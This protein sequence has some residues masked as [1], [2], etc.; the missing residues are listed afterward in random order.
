MALTAK[1]VYAI[2]KRQISDME[3]K[4]NSPVR[5]RGTVATAD[6]LPL[7]PDIG[8]MYNIESK[9]IYG[10]AGMNVAWNG[11][12]WDTMGA[13]I[14][15]SLYIK[16]SE[17]SDWVKQQNKPTYTAEEVGALPDTT[18]IPSKTSEL[19]NDS[20]FLT[21]IPDNYLSGTDKTL[22]V[23]GKAADA[24]ATG[25]KITELSADI[26]KKLNKNQGSENSGKIAGI[27]ES[28][29]IVPMFPVSV[30]YNEETNCLE[31]GSDQKMELNKGINLDSTLT[32]TGSAA[33]AGAV[34]EITNSLKEDLD[35]ILSPNLYN[36]ADA[37]ENTAINQDD[38]TEMPF[39]GWLATGY[40]PVSKN[41]VL[42]FSSNE[43]PIPYSTGAFYDKNKQRVDSFGNPNN[44]NNI[45]VTSDGYARFSFGTAPMNLQI[46]KG[47]R[48]TYVPYGELK[49]KVE[50]DNVKEDIAHTKAEVTGIKA[51]V[52]K[53]QEDHTN[54]FN[55]DTVIKGAV[56]SE[57]GY[58]ETS[59]SSWDS[60][61]YIPIKPGMILYFSSNELPIGVASTGAYFDADKKYLSGINNEPTVLTV[62]NGAYYLRF[63][64][65]GGLGD[66]LNTLK[67]EQH[68]ITKFTPYGELYV[69]VNES[70]LPNSILPKWKGLKIL[71]LGDSITAMGGVNGW[72]HWIKQ[73]LLADKVVNVSVA[74]STWQDK[75]ASQTYDGNPQPSTDGNV[76]GNQVQKV[77]NAKANGD[78]DY[79]DFDVITFSFGTN[80]SIDFSVQTKGSVENQFIT[81]YAQNN[82]TVVPLESVNRQT[83]AGAMRY[84]FQKL[85]E[86]YP[87][88]VIFM[89]TP[90]QE[91]YETFDSIYQK[92][93]FIN[94]VADRLGAETI[95]TRRCGIRNIYES[96]T[97]IDYDHPEQSG[98][99]P[100][101]TDL[102]DGIHTNENGAKKIAK[103]NAREIIKYFMIN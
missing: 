83:L 4:L 45:T 100:I 98:V 69:T 28:G 95:D 27:N 38:G 103:Y 39:D 20:G 1:K 99:A 23:S 57:N 80:D 54:L 6:L 72:T 65:N 70:A 74:G 48:T 79:Q 43:E 71:T 58:L 86:A 9:S 13:P 67:I 11:V 68:G 61:D 89:C 47:S 17:L 64:K 30:D 55:K 50:V 5:Y 53:I 35:N 59:F 36:P 24:K 102:L 32:K 101:Q 96:Q 8:D 56:L 93:D 81:N 51:E 31:F 46:E 37:K 19:Q 92:G 78:A 18:V 85:H 77:L 88:A 73:Y 22:N 82:F 94:F 40:I 21:K 63:S 42:Y 97:T 7:N 76:M 16:S 34:G 33:D 15:M 49:V 52:V 62:P 12:V 44:N 87:N 29:D 66:T 25:D 91:C 60:S 84:G 10:E 14:D 3:A 2:L 90:T 41:D 26:S 75:V